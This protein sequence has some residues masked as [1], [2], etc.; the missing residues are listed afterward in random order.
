MLLSLRISDCGDTIPKTIHS[1]T[2]WFLMSFLGS[3]PLTS[4]PS[5]RVYSTARQIARFSHKTIRFS[6]I[7]FLHSTLKA[8]LALKNKEGVGKNAVR[9]LLCEKSR[10]LCTLYSYYRE[11]ICEGSESFSENRHFSR[12]VFALKPSS[13]SARLQ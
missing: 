11:V 9:K 4:R 7:T 2:Q 1:S 8:S 6:L 13:D 10:L 12:S 5:L 3:K